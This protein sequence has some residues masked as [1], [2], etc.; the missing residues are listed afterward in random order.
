[1][2]NFAEKAVFEKDKAKCSETDGDAEGPEFAPEKQ[3]YDQGRGPG[4]DVMEAA[5]APL[6]RHAYEAGHRVEN[7]GHDRE[8]EQTDADTVP[9]FLDAHVDADAANQSERGE[10]VGLPAQIVKLEA[11]V[12]GGKREREERPERGEPATAGRNLVP[13]E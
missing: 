3:R 6:L 13:H 12:D 8:R 1:L 2:R 11:A 7:D 4:I 10:R 9:G 5:G